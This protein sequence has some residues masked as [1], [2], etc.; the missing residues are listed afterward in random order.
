MLH[1]LET[2]LIPTKSLRYYDK[3]PRKG[4]VAAVKESLKTNGQFK[5]IVVRESDKRVLAGNHTLKAARELGWDEISA[6]LVNVDDDAARRIVLAD[7][8]TSDLAT[9]DDAILLALLKDVGDDLIGTG[10]DLGDVLDLEMESV[11]LNT[12]EEDWVSGDM[13]IHYDMI[14]DDEEQQRAFQ[15]FIKRLASEYPDAHTVAERVYL[16]IKQWEGGNRA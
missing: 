9:Y 3:N 7:N 15:A 6:V 13:V 4:D 10:Y 5:P 16:H 12:E 2:R 8:R 14:F 11:G 1:D